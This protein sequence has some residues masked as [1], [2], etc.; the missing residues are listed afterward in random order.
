VARLDYA[1]GR[2]GARR[3]SLLGA[4]GLRRLLS[5]GTL[6]ARLA[7][8]REGGHA[9]EPSGEL[10]ADPVA[11]LESA[12]RDAWRREAA[13]LVEDVEGA[14][15]RRLLGAFLSLADAVAVKAVLRGVALGAAPDRAAAPAFAAPGLGD[16]A[17][18]AAASAPSLEAAV[19]SLARSGCALA[20]A[21]RT[22]LPL[23]G[24][25]LL[26]LEI[27]VDRA[28]LARAAASCAGGGE[29]AGI[30]RAHLADRADVRNATT[31]LALDGA[32]PA[33]DPFVPGGRRLGADAL[34]SLLGRTGAAPRAAIARALGVREAEL[35][36]PWS[37]DRALERAAR[38]PLRREARLRPLSIAVPL[39]YLA[40]RAA[41]V[42]GIALVVR[43]TALGV[44]AA[45][46]LDLAEA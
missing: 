33:S 25:G 42:R 17:L 26:P 24:G 46:L 11:S 20:E 15:V 39:A 7:L 30:L 3:A 45:E 19:E 6:E 36:S 10:G 8:L 14:H 44:D 41:E 34:R 2:L 40:D 27:A 22:A 13:A 4:A 31:L 29:D 16:A 37:A 32:E 5:C 9:G 43:G 18:R 38:A 28:A 21:A 1:N 35:A 12:L 23:G